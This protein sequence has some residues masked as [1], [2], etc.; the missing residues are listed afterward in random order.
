[1]ILFI[2]AGEMPAP[3]AAAGFV[4]RKVEGDVALYLLRPCFPAE[5][6][7]LLL[8]GFDIY[9]RLVA[10]ECA[11]GDCIGRCSIPPRCWQG[12]LGRGVATVLMAH[13]HPSGAAWPSVAD[14]RCTHETA[15]FLRL[16]DIELT[17]HLIFVDT[18]HFSFRQA[19]LM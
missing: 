2:S 6:E 17:D 10:L 3:Y 16:L 11:D 7:A 14:I 9:D 18:G 8:A 13:N 5:G 19:Q 4:P 12:L 15:Q 1:M